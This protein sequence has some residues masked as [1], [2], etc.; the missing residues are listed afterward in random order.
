[1]E[2]LELSRKEAT[3]ELSNII[4][5]NIILFALVFDANREE[6]IVFGRVACAAPGACHIVHAAVTSYLVTYLCCG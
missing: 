3:V 1:M 4:A 5:S 6:G 2:W